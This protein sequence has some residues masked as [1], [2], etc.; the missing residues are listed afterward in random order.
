MTYSSE[1]IILNSTKVGE[2]SLVLHCL[3]PC[4][5]RRSFICSVSKNNQA[6]FMPLSIIDAE[7]IENRHSDLWRLRSVSSL[8]PLFSLRS[9][10]SKNSICMFMSEVLYRV[11]REGTMEPGLFEWCRSS[12]LMLDTLEGNFSNFHLRFLLELASALGFS[13]DIEALAPFV[14]ARYK[15]LGYLLGAS[16][17][18]FMLYPLNGNTRSEIA[19]ALLNYLAYHCEIQL[20]IRSLAVL[21]ELF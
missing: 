3:S 14:G 8:N 2:K 16:V 1:L 13:P 12:I 10:S 11:L 19:E 20:E 9:H 17:A 7:L 18:E 6:Y 15:D 5:G 4:W 21:K